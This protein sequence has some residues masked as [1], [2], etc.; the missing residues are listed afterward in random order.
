MGDALVPQLLALG[1]DIVSSAQD[2]TQEAWAFLRPRAGLFLDR[3]EL[4]QLHDDVFARWDYEVAKESGALLDDNGLL[5]PSLTSRSAFGRS[6]GTRAR[7]T[8]RTATTSV[9]TA[10]RS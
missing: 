5:S 2:G 8:G 7:R 3:K 6:R 4:G 1:P 9:T 10:L